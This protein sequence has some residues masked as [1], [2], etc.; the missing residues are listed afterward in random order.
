MTSKDIF[1]HCVWLVC[2]LSGTSYLGSL[3]VEAVFPETTLARITVRLFEW[4]T[5]MV[6]GYVV[7]AG[8]LMAAWAIRQAM[9]EG[10]LFYTDRSRL[11]V[12]RATAG[13]ADNYLPLEFTAAG[14]PEPRYGN[15][16]W[17]D[18]EIA[19]VLKSGGTHESP[20]ADGRG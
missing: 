18:D 6:S 17:L 11:G 2:G 16:G 9:A 14:M 8:G 10:R 3:F 1:L 4:S 15:L 19:D 5:W 20:T 12:Y 7:L 13:Q